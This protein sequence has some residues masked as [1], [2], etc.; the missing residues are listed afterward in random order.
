MT[1]IG[2]PGS[3]RSRLPNARVRPFQLMCPAS[4]T[5]P[6]TPMPG[7][8]RY[9]ATVSGSSGADMAPSSSCPTGTIG[10]STPSEGIAS[11]IGGTPHAPVATGS[12]SNTGAGMVSAPVLLVSTPA[13]GPGEKSGAGPSVGGIVRDADDDGVAV[14]A[15]AGEDDEDSDDTSDSCART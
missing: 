14:G 5:L 12:G 8:N 4:T 15:G 11:L 6:G 13:S 7:P 1:R 9:Q 10:A 3:S 2:S